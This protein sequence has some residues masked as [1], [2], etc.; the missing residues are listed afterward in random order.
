[1]PSEAPPHTQGPSSN[2]T[3]PPAE[4]P[5]SF[6]QYV[7][8]FGPGFI[9][10]LTWLGAGDIV[11][12]GVAGGNYGY[13][14]AWAM[15]LALAVRYAFV[16]MIARFQL[17]NPRGEGVLDGLVRFHRFYGPFLFLAVLFWGHL[18]TTYMLAGVGEIS[19]GITGLGSSFLWQIFWVVVVL[20][21]IFRPVYHRA[22]F[23]FKVLLAVLA[24]MAL[25]V[26][27]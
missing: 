7:R 27:R 6:W 10:V 19:A 1:M 11:S 24:V 23:I 15:V 3:V 16:S 22:E 17:C 26:C 25:G 4:I 8:S 13:A 18:S 2:G 14:L 21:I 9:A 12:A 20:S 5:S